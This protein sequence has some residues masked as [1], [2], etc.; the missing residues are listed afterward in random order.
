MDPA[1]DPVAD[2]HVDELSDG[3]ATH[4]RERGTEKLQPVMLVARD[5]PVIT[6]ASKRAIGWSGRA[7]NRRERM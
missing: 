5:L 1:L 6:V 7:H 4:A 3:S 2:E